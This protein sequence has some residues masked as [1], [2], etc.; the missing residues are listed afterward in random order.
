M[1]EDKLDEEP[2]S[3]IREQQHLT[4]YKGRLPIRK[5]VQRNSH[6]L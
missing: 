3:Q 6:P 5:E 1:V 2:T 4:L